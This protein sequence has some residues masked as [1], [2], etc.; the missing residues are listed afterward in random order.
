MVIANQ[1]IIGWIIQSESEG[2]SDPTESL[3]AIEYNMT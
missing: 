1:G 2:N 3:Y